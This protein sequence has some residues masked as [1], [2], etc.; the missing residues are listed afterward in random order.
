MDIVPM[1]KA[2]RLRQTFDIVNSPQ[3]L[4]TE[5]VIHHDIFFYE[6]KFKES[7]DPCYSSTISLGSI[8]RYN[9]TNQCCETL[10]CISEIV[11]LYMQHCWRYTM[12]C[13][14]WLEGV[15]RDLDQLTWHF[16]SLVQC[17]FLSICW[18][19]QKECWFQQTQSIQPRLQVHPWDE[20]HCRLRSQQ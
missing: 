9:F 16:R 8:V 7:A 14:L 18:K 11:C 1:I 13:Q 12:K 17:W 19:H 6:S 10:Y 15:M 2:S 20:G 4:E 3:L 5:E